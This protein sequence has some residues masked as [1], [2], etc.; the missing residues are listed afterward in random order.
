MLWLVSGRMIENIARRL[1][2]LSPVLQNTFGNLLLK[3]RGLYIYIII[4]T[5]IYTHNIIILMYMTFIILV[6]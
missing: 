1:N 5:I 6:H 2:N 3:E 4:Y